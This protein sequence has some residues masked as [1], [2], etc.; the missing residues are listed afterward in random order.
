MDADRE[1]GDIELKVAAAAKQVT[2]SRANY[3]RIPSFFSAVL[4]YAGLSPD[5]WLAIF[6]PQRAARYSALLSGTR[7]HHRKQNTGILQRHQAV[8]FPSRQ[9]QKLPGT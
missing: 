2:K 6:S 7:Q 1:N 5:G 4:D 9:I 8:W 3:L